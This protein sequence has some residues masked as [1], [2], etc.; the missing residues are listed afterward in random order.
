MQKEDMERLTRVYVLDTLISQSGK[1]LTPD[2]I[3]QLTGEL[4]GRIVDLI[5][6]LGSCDHYWSEDKAIVCIKCKSG[7]FLHD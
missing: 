3:G 5:N 1:Q 7:D 6:P 2:V 4:V